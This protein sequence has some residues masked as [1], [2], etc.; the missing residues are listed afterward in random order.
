MSLDEIPRLEVVGIRRREN[1]EG[2]DPLELLHQLVLDIRPPAALGRLDPGQLGLLPHDGATDERRLESDDVIQR[3]VQRR[4][5]AALQQLVLHAVL[6]DLGILAGRLAYPV[7]Q[8]LFHNAG[9]LSHLVRRRHR[10]GLLDQRHHLLLRH[11]L[12]RLHLLRIQLRYRRRLHAPG[13]VGP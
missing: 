10:A 2:T 3:Q 8:I 12:R 11:H 7:E 4:Q 13:F 5:E 1:V 9:D 6:G